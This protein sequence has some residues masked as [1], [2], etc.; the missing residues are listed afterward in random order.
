LPAPRLWWLLAGAGALSLLT[1]SRVYLSLSIKGMAE[2]VHAIAA[3]EALRWCLW[4]PVVP[5]VL[6][7]E[8]RWGFARGPWSTAI[9]GHSAVAI[10][11]LLTHTVV[12]TVAGS[13]AG[14]YFML[15]TPRETLLV[16][17]VHEGPAALL[18]Y[19][20]IVGAAHARRHVHERAAQAL[21]HSSLEARLARERLRNLQ[22]QLHPHF[23]FNTL[24]AVGGII[25]DGDRNVA[26]ETISDLGNLLRRS[27]EQADRQLVTLDEELDF[28]GAYLK[29]QKA[30]YG[31][32]LTVQVD[33]DA[34][35][36]RALVPNLLLQPLVENA[37]RH[38]T[39]Q[40]ES[41]GT[42]TVRAGANDTRVVL[43]VCND[44]PGIVDDTVAEGIGL[45]NTRERLAEIYGSAGSFR[46]E[47]LDHGGGTRVRIEIPL[48]A[49]DGPAED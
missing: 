46:I 43:E 32:R 20:A 45:A 16:Q 13:W 48:Q 27:L 4:I 49:D 17:L 7:I 19:G 29:I 40:M 23:L 37:I 47:Q 1:A 9:A 6:A 30:R 38:G 35:T 26:V 24:H 31:S 14:W 44:G 2:P 5:L 34:Q 41:G 36:R 39:S 33:A 12:M 28:I 21:A 8:R 25:R 15:D 3:S 22:M 18:V 11:V 42:V 10:G